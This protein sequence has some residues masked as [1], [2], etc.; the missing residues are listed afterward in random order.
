MGLGP[1]VLLYS[2]GQTEASPARWQVW[3]L[4][5]FMTTSDVVI[6]MS[7]HAM[8]MCENGKEIVLNAFQLKSTITP[9]CA[10]GVITLS[11]L[12]LYSNW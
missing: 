10:D 9:Q 12:F 5:S 6:F 8:C 2:H 3:G 1:E 4:S 7:I 11:I